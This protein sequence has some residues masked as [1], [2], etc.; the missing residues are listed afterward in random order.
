MQGRKGLRTSSHANFLEAT[1]PT[2]VGSTCTD[3]TI[4]VSPIEQTATP[5]GHFKFGY[6]AT[7]VKVLL[8]CHSPNPNQAHGEAELLEQICE[9]IW[10]K[11][12]KVSLGKALNPGIADHTPIFQS[13]DH[14]RCECRVYQS[15]IEGEDIRAI[16]EQAWKKE[17]RC[18]IWLQRL[19]GASLIICQ[20][21]PRL[22]MHTYTTLNQA[23]QGTCCVL[24]IAFLG[25]IGR[26][27]S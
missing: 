10:K 1:I 20:V 18:K 27:C 14:D 11:K 23:H 6:G 16:C 21:V 7:K 26:Q 25:Y 13:L 12:H 15:H 22:G 8:M 9:Q 24:I 5:Q 3:T 2:V 19:K 17:Q 4:S